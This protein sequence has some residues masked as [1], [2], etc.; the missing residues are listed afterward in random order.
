MTACMPRS[1]NLPRTGSSQKI[2]LLSVIYKNM[3]IPS[4]ILN[5]D[6]NSALFPDKRLRGL[7]LFLVF[8]FFILEELITRFKNVF[9]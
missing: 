2:Y 4:F 9:Y 3:S 8:T 5:E 1:F 6:S 7:F